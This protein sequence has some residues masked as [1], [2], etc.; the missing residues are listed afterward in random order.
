MEFIEYPDRD[1][2]MFDLANA[3]AGELNAA[4][5]THDTASFAVPGGSTPGPV[6]DALCAA[7]LEWERITVLAGDERR[8]PADH[9]RSNERMIR[10]R[11]LTSKAAAAN[12]VSI[13]PDGDK[14]PD[15]SA[16]LPLSVLVVGMGEDMH[17]ASLFPGSPDLEA[18]LA[19]DAPDLMLV[20]ASDGLEPRVT[21]SGRVLEEAMSTHVLIAGKEKRE[22]LERAQHSTRLE[23]PIRTVLANATVH[24]AP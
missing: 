22:A 17:T 23:A 1:L 7:P 4:L 16:H 15:I 18:A 2:M 5:M 12:Y 3:L 8:V 21:L 13:R 20:E 9:E 14:L 19:P 24:W 6:F 10:A 11:L